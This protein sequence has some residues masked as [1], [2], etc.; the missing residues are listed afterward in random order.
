MT[1]HRGQAPVESWTAALYPRH[2]VNFNFKIPTS[3][4][5]SEATCFTYFNAEFRPIRSANPVGKNIV[6]LNHHQTGVLL[7]RGSCCAHHLGYWEAPYW[8]GAWPWYFRWRMR[9]VP[10]SRKLVWVQNEAG[11]NVIHRGWVGIKMSARMVHCTE[12]NGRDWH[13]RRI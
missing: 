1:D 2:A 4:A 8:S 6:A 12:Q 7:H 9:H 5:V 3:V 13:L 10:K 11:E